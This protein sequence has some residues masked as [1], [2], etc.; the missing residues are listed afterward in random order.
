MIQQYLKE[1]NLITS[2]QALQEETRV[3]LNV[4]DD[5][6]KLTFDILNGSNQTSVRVF[7]FSF[8]WTVVDVH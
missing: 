2:L 5:I 3:T 4:V 6:S 8:F 1:N 7:F